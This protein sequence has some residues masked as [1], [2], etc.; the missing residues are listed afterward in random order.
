MRETW[1]LREDS[2]FPSAETAAAAMTNLVEMTWGDSSVL[3]G[4]PID[5]ETR[6]QVCGTDRF[7]APLAT[8]L[9]AVLRRESDDSERITREELLARAWHVAP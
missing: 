1:C 6:V 3:N 5:I 7:A 9:V 8:G 2:A 4:P